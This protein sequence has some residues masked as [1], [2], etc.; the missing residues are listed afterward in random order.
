MRPLHA[1]AM[2]LHNM[3]GDPV[4]RVKRPIHT[5]TAYDMTIFSVIYLMMQW[6]HAPKTKASFMRKWKVCACEYVCVRV[7]VCV[8]ACMY[9]CVFVCTYAYMTTHTNVATCQ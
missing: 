8:C 3:R 1:C 4:M 6:G 9:V 7:F 5:C 2:N